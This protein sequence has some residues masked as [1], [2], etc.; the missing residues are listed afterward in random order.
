MLHS[1]LRLPP[2]VSGSTRLD[3]RDG[4]IFGTRIGDDDD[5]KQRLQLPQ[6]TSRSDALGW[7]HALAR[8]NRHRKS[9]PACERRANVPV[10]A[11]Q[12]VDGS[13][14]QLCSQRMQE[15][16]GRNEQGDRLA[17]VDHAAETDVA[18]R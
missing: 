5:R 13:R 9:A 16:S 11:F 4:Q 17:H 18:G 14:V 7:R 12:S 10:A 3:G 8:D 6:M 15:V 2:S 1:A